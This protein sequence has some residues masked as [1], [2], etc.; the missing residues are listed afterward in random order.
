ME[1]GNTL[2]HTLL[3]YINQLKD[4]SFISKKDDFILSRF[5]ISLCQHIQDTKTQV[6]IGYMILALKTNPALTHSIV[7]IRDNNETLLSVLES[8]G[9][10]RDSSQILVKYTTKLLWP[11][12]LEFF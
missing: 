10:S 7:D 2:S 1:Q 11:K 12:T 3:P 6:G 9:Y 5:M 8:L 4:F